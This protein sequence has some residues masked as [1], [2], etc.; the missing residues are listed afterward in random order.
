MESR[1]GKNKRLLEALLREG[2]GY[3]GPSRH[4]GFRVGL[5]FLPPGCC[6]FR[7]GLEYTHFDSKGKSSAEAI[8]NARG[9]YQGVPTLPPTVPPAADNFYVD[10]VA[11]ARD[12]HSKISLYVDYVDFN[13]FGSEC[14]YDT[15]VFHWTFGARGAVIRSNWRTLYTI[16]IAGEEIKLDTFFGEQKTQI[17]W[18]YGAGGINFSGGFAYQPCLGL[19]FYQ[20]FTGSLLLGR[21]RSSSKATLDLPIDGIVEI[22]DI[23]GSRNKIVPVLQSETGIEW[24]H[25]LD[26][27]YLFQAKVAFEYMKWF[28]IGENRFYTIPVGARYKDVCSDLDLYG[29][30]VG[31]AVG[32]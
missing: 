32:F 26:C 12:G 31:V 23:S 13:I 24:V 4:S 29:L 6:S 1:Q 30:T 14:Y 25:Q 5:G 28:Q 18:K 17:D 8:A 9:I 11:T 19:Q 21:L 20:D 15:C 16:Q 27:G 22:C 10:G 2:P 7:P 3:T